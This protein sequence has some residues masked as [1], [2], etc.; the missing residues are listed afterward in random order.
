MKHGM[1]VY[2]RVFASLFGAVGLTE[3]YGV[4]VNGAWWN[5]IWVALSAVMVAVLVHDARK[6]ASHGK[7]PL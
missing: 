2:D 7:A 1:V 4:V 5:I 3:A 6:E